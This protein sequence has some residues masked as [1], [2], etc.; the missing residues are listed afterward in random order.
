MSATKYAILAF[1]LWGILPIYLK[2]IPS[3]NAYEITSYRIIFSFISLLIF[4]IC[5][6]SKFSIRRDTLTLIKDKSLYLSSILIGINW[7]LFVYCIEEGK[8]L[9]AS[10]GYFSGPLISIFLG[11]LF[12]KEKVSRLKIF[13]ILLVV[14]SII[15]Q[16]TTINKIPYISITLALSFA[17][18]GLIKKITKPHPFKSLYF[19]SLL[20]S[21]FGVIYLL[22][23]SSSHYTESI[24]LTEAIFIIFSGLITII[25]LILFTKAASNLPLNILG[26]V[27]Y[28]APLTQ[29]LIAILIY[30]ENLIFEKA[31]SFGLV[32]IS[33][34]IILVEQNFNLRKIS[35]ER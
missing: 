24:N 18:Y 30:K 31:I 34:M 19:E 14:A 2:Q 32:W 25:P 5:K 20:I 35:H 15:V 1:F 7:F 9:E 10:F 17:L 12:L 3:L 33:C 23:I 26:L 29:F 21:P 22:F 4:L 16:A 8:I 11:L 27:Q 6:D 28:I 13:A